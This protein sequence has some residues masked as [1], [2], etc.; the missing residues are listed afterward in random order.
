MRRDEEDMEM[1]ESVQQWEYFAGWFDYNTDTA[2]D[3]EE[4]TTDIHAWLDMKG[5]EGWELAAALPG[6]TKHSETSF[7]FKRPKQR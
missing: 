7:F 1:S 3:T 2:C 6:H 4:G 5:K